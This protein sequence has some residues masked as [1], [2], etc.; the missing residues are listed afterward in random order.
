MNI[1]AFSTK[2]ITKDGTRYNNRNPE[3]IDAAVHYVMKGNK[4]AKPVYS[5]STGFTEDKDIRKMSDE[6]KDLQ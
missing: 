2:T 3:D 1:S 4:E 6:I 5:S